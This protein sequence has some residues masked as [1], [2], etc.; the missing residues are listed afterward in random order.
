LLTHRFKRI[1]EAGAFKDILSLP[2]AIAGFVFS[3]ASCF[4]AHRFLKAG[5]T[6]YWPR[7]ERSGPEPAGVRGEGLP[8]IGRFKIH[9]E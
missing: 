7:A 4:A 5:D 2:A 9:Q 6:H 3:L 8:Q 1:R